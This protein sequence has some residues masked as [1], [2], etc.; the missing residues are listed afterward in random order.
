MRK[1]G[2]IGYPLSHSF[3]QRFFTE[4]FEREGITGC[5]YETYPLKDISELPALLQDPDLCGLNVTIPYKEQVIPFLQEKNDIVA[6]INACNCIRIEKGQLTGYN[7]DVIGFEISLL[8]KWQPHHTHALILGTGGAAKAVEFVV[9]KLGLDYRFV[10][11]SPRPFTNDLYYDQVNAELIRSHTLI[12]NTS[13]LGMYPNT[14]HFPLLPYEAITARHYL[15]DLV[16]NPARTLF[17]QKG[18]ERGAVVEN[19]YEM[20]I[21]QAEESWSI[22]DRQGRSGL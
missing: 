21:L 12:V 19:G 9:R 14:E 20:L 8:K 5:V 16:Y 7:T 15:F 1:F 10:S 22:W 4:K 6:A 3:S 13:P 18:E 11:R 17:L 2:L